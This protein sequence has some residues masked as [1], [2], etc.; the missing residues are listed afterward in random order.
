MRRSTI[1]WLAVNPDPGIIIVPI[2]KGP[3]SPPYKLWIVEL[4]D[5]LSD[6]L[7]E[8]KRPLQV[9]YRARLDILGSERRSIDFYLMYR[10]DPSKTTSSAS[11]APRKFFP[12][13]RR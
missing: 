1:P 6:T 4:D 8:E 5:M 13:A 10:L 12:T 11:P 7:L 9:V 2:C 3:K